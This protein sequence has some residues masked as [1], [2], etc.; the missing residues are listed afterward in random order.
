[1]EVIIIALDKQVHLYAVDT[2]AFYTDEEMAIEKEISEL[3]KRKRQNKA[4]VDLMEEYHHGGIK[5]GKLRKRLV[6]CKYLSQKEDP[7]PDDDTIVGLKQESR[8]LAQEISSKKNE[9]RKVFDDFCGVRQ[10]RNEFLTDF[11]VISIFESYLIR[12]IGVQAGELSRDLLVVKTCYF[13]VLQDIIYNGFILDGDKYVIYT[14]SAGQIRT[15]RSVFI[16]ESVLREHEMTLMCGLTVDHINEL[17]GVNTNKYLAYLALSNSAT[18]E[19]TD[20]DIDRC[21][22]VDDFET[23]VHGVVDYIDDKTYEITRQ[24]MGVPITHTDGAGMILPSV[25]KKNF[26]CRLPWVKGLLASFP[27]DKFIREANR[28]EPKVNHGIVKDIYGQEHDVLAENIQI[29]FTKSQFKMSKYYSNWEEYKT[30]FKK[31]NCQAGICNMEED[32]FGKAKINYQMLQTLTDLSDDE[33][34]E[35]MSA[36]VSKLDRTCHDRETMLQVFGATRSN[37]RP[38]AFQRAL[39]LYPEL[40]QDEYS[41]DTL[42]LIRAKLER[43]A[44]AGRLD[45]EGYYTFIVPDLYAFCQRL[46]LR[47]ENPTGL[48]VDGEVYC[49]LF[50]PGAE[51]DCLRSPHLYREHAVRKNMFGINDEAK[52][53]FATDALY[54]SDMDLISRVLQF[55]CDGDK[56]LVVSD[57]VLV[58]AAKR[59]MD[60]IVPLYYPGLKA[61]PS[62]ITPENI[63][64]SMTWAYTSCNVGVVSNEI[65]RV[66]SSDQEIDL[67]LVKFLT[68]YNNLVIDA[69]KNLYLPKK[70]ED[71]LQRLAPYTKSKVPH[72]FMEAKQKSRKQVASI[73]GSTVNRIRGLLPAMRLNFNWDSCGKFDWRVLCSSSVIPRNDITQKIVDMFKQRSRRMRF[74]TDDE[75]NE[76]NRVFLCEQ[77]RADLLSIHP[78]PHFV[79]DVLVRELF[80]PRHSSKRKIVFWECFGGEVVEH[81]QKN[82]NQNQKMC[83]RCGKRYYREAAN[84]VLCPAC[85]KKQRRQYK[86]QWDRN[87]R[88]C[89]QGNNS[90]VSHEPHGVQKNENPISN[91]EDFEQSHGPHGVQ[92]I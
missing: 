82:V 53:W 77:L 90:F 34:W 79:C 38:S 61:P 4:V 81:L 56:A 57:K 86:T 47:E 40:L 6:D 15:K 60:G 42:R 9:L 2:K 7:L 21:I 18:D 71:I 32:E 59:N 52:R 1:M 31:Y 29:I 87:K 46:F 63:Y 83:T 22:V 76:S 74:K 62:A 16:R 85:Q 35:I 14:A 69:A 43:E 33:L 27:F 64:K 41:R 26:M 17:G 20:F 49:R 91:N 44:V 5:E 12:T 50:E 67:D 45:V 78:D 10:F 75:T 24:E 11:N 84:Q 28:K 23:E 73:N 88:K 68:L 8:R 36:T 70:P 54:T 51:L 55:D 37:T 25:S 39:L 65:T 92:R 89:G 3:R 48:L 72:F 58:D 19:W 30:F 13:K 80:D 66:W